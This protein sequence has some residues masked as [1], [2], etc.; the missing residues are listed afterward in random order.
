MTGNGVKPP[1]AQ[2]EPSFIVSHRSVSNSAAAGSPATV[3]A[4]IAEFAERTQA[5]EL[6]IN[7]HIYDH[8]KRL[9]SF[10]IIAEV[11]VAKD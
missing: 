11:G 7:S 8:D 2:S 1:S 6:I 4:G 5:D 10:E 9:R 3:R